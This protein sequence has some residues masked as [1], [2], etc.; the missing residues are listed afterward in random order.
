MFESLPHWQWIFALV[1]VSLVGIKFPR[2][3]VIVGVVLGFLWALGHAYLKLYP[4]LD[5]SLEGIDLEVTGKIVS[6]PSMQGRSTR[7][8]FLIFTANKTNN[9]E[10]VV[11]PSKVR[12][13]WFGKAPDLQL[14][15]QW[16]LRVRLK[17]PWGYVNPGSFDYE[18]WLFEHEI[19]ATGYVRVK[20]NVKRI[21]PT[22]I[23]NPMHFFRAWLNKR[24]QLASAGTNTPVIKALALGERGEINP[25]HWKVLTG[26]GTNH[27]LA[28]SGLH[29]GLVSGL[30]YM[31]VLQLWKLSEFL[32]LRIAAQRV[33]AL[34]GI[35]AGVMYAMLAGFSIP[36]Q[37]AMIMATIVLMAV[38]FG[39]SLRPWSILSIALFIVLI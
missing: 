35:V 29:V 5:K 26:T 16:Q 21:K 17:R 28:I 1:P 30:V 11:V 24:L 3:I 15:E 4:A 32:C 37:R 18:K 22:S 14:G 10:K 33:A 9:N 23:S 36:T 20:G 25:Q 7:F 2:S 39:K 12:L 13:N 38:Y 19:R 27:L 8:E 31:L 6:I 34:A